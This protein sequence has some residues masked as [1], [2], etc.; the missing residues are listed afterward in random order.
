MSSLT[1][2]KTAAKEGAD[3]RPTRSVSSDLSTVVICD[4][5]TTEGFGSPPSPIRNST[6]PGAAA[7]FL[8]DVTRHT[9]VVAIRLWLNASHCTTTQGWRSAGAEP[10]ADPKSSQ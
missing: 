10:V 5:F 7:R 2:R 1:P 6:L 3:K 4:T 8:F 9:T